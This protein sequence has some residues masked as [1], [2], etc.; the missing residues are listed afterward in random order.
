MRGSSLRTQ[1]VPFIAKN[2][3]E[4]VLA[5]YCLNEAGKLKALCF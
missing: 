4:S 1:P 5:L 2:I 3:A